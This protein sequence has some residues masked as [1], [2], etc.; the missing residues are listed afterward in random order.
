MGCGMSSTKPPGAKPSSAKPSSAE[1]E[2]EV[3]EEEALAQPR[4]YCTKCKKM[5]PSCRNGGCE[6]C[7]IREQNRIVYN[8]GLG[9]LVSVDAKRELSPRSANYTLE[10]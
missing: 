5:Q 7:G 3:L 4:I 9:G 8:G 10:E 6:V 2:E 1:L